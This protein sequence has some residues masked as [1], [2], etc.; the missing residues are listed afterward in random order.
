MP[1]VVYRDQR[2]SVAAGGNLLSALLEVGVNVSHG[3]RSGVCRSCTMVVLD[4]TVPAAS[5]ADLTAAERGQGLF[6]P[7]QCAVQDDLVIG[8]VSDRLEVGAHIASIDRMRS[9]VIRLRLALDGELDFVP[10]Q[11]ATLIRADGLARSYS[12]ANQPGARSLEFHVGVVAGGRMSEWVQTGAREGDAVRV[13]GPYGRCCYDPEAVASD[14]P[15]LLAGVGTGLA[16]LWGIAN[17]ALAR[18]HT[19]PI[20]ILHGARNEEGLYLDAELTNLALGHENVE[21]RA[22]VLEGA[23]DSAQR[24]PLDL[25]AIKDCATQPLAAHTIYLC[26]APEFVQGL[27]RKLFLAGCSLSRIL[28]D[29]FVTASA[30]TP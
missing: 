29:A 7:C 15:L 11:F 12:I 24:R 26:G 22:F 1:T 14:A 17:D 2:H 3:C 30:P 20:A 21:Y 25:N 19:G 28:A 6:L 10:G 8:D 16:P 4:G 13:R 5:Q 27:R 9:R 23:S 18:G